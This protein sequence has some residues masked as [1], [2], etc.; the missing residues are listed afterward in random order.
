MVGDVFKCMFSEFVS[1]DVGECGGCLINGFV[2]GCARLEDADDSVDSGNV[3][4]W[5]E[6]LVYNEGGSAVEYRLIDGLFSVVIM[7]LIIP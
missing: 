4:L 1:I 5:Y 2:E 6:V 7:F 3:R